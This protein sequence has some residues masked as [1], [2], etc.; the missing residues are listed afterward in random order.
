MEDDLGWSRSF[1]TGVLSVALVIGALL[2]IGVGHWL[3]R[4][5]PRRLLI[6]GAIL[7]SVLVAAWSAARSKPVFLAVWVGLGGCQA[8]LFYEPAFTVLTKWFAGA[9]RHRAVTAVTLMAGLASTIFGPLTAALE[10]SFG[11]RGAALTLAIVLAAV[12]LPAFAIGLRPPA[13]TDTD[14]EEPLPSHAPRDAFRERRFW[15]VASAYL[16][17]SITTFAVGVLLVAFLREARGL[18]NGSAAIALGAVGLVQVAGRSAFARLSSVR[19]AIQLGTAVMVAKAVGLAFLLAIPNVVG[20]VAFVA[21]Y[22][23]ANGLSTLTRATTIAE[24]YGAQHYGAISSVVASIGSV[25]GAIAP[26]AAAAA[27]DVVG[28]ERP[29]WG[30]FIVISLLAAVTNAQARRL[31]P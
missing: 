19:S 6:P 3:D 7:A 11:W 4:N 18:D 31:R 17:S 5:E 29:V 1:L 21:I 2:G 25:G 9:A 16:L 13:G 24:L 15:F 27:I 23:A 26:F 22:G 20:V 10:R 30:S 8:L 28:D 12:T 14:A